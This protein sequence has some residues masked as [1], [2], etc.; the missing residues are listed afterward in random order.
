MFNQKIEYL[1]GM[2]RMR[3]LERKDTTSQILLLVGVTV[4][5]QQHSSEQNM[6]GLICF[7]LELAFLSVI[8]SY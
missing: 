8:I 3:H 6:A 4:G 1:Y 7:F 2:V 5:V